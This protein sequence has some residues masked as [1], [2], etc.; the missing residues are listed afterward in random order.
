[1]GYTS[2]VKI[3][4]YTLDVAALPLA[5]LKLWFDENYP[6]TEAREWEAEVKVGDD[7][8]VV[9]Y[10]GV[11]WYEQYDHPTNVRAAIQSFV[12][13][14]ETDQYETSHAAYEMV[15]VGEDLADIGIDRS[16]NSEF[17]LNVSRSIEFM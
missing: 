4:F 7:Y 8:V 12:N 10:E 17:R 1:M 2:D 13:T 11:K 6:L 14:F 3:V 15:E 16:N 5:A 9:S